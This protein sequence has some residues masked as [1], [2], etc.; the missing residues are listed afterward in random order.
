MSRD[1]LMHRIVGERRIPL[2]SELYHEGV[3]QFRGNLAAL[4][5]RYRKAGVPVFIGTLAS[6]VKGLEPFISAYARQDDATAADYFALGRA[7]EDQGEYPRAREAYLAAKDRDQLRFRAPEA[8]NAIIR[9]VAEQLG[10]RVVEVQD[11]LLQAAGNGII[12]NDLMLEHL[13]PNLEG[14]SLLADAYYAALHE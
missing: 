6:N 5:E 7:L 3:A 4:L 2:D 13:H 12:G 11:R 1:T 14:Y 8:F 9:E 10:A